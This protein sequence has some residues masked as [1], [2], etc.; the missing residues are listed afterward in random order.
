MRNTPPKK[1]IEQRGTD[2]LID[3]LC[4]GLRDVGVG[5][6]GLP[7]DERAK[8]AIWEVQ[9]ISAEVKIRNAD[10]A[11]FQDRIKRLSEETGWQ[12]E[13]YDVSLEDSHCARCLVDEQDG[14]GGKSRG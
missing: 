6:Y 2:E 14:R 5:D 3:D 12:D 13:E 11:D 10:N 1:T 9:L 4:L 7:E 8:S